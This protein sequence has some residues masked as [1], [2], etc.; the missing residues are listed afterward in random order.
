MSDTQKSLET[1]LGRRRFL[2][3]AGAGALGLAGAALLAKGAEAAPIPGGL[4]AAVLNF[5]LNLEYLEAEFYAHAV[6]G[7]G[8]EALNIPVDGSDGTK[9]GPVVVKPMGTTKVPFADDNIRQY[10]EEIA[11]DEESH[12]VFIQNA[13]KKVGVPYVAR[14]KIDLYNSFRAL[15]SLIGAPNFDPFADDVSFLLGAYIFEDVGVTAYHGGAP[16]LSNKTILNYAAG[17]LAVEAYHAG[18]VRTKLFELKQGPATQAISDVRNALGGPSKDSNGQ[19]VAPDYGVTEPVKG[20]GT[21]SSIVLTD[22][23]ALAFARTTQQVIN[24][25]YADASGKP[26]GFFPNGL[27]GY[28]K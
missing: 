8:L 18:L 10:A 1:L 15:G 24:I 9:A 19:F 17:I 11:S 4:D 28:V 14:P 26:G 3:T 22:S 20:G 7:A 21:T 5:A 2:K 25:V 16:L 6:T 27:N 12:V 23:N 13:L